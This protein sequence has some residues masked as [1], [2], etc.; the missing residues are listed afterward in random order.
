MVSPSVGWLSNFLK[1]R[2]VHVLE[3]FITPVLVFKFI[4]K[5]F[6]KRPEQGVNILRKICSLGFKMSSL[7]HL[8]PIDIQRRFS[9]LNIKGKKVRK[10]K[11][12]WYI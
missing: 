1:S 11:K 6:Y 2:Q 12:I 8:K 10:A 3:E 5:L 9:Q 4:F 7:T